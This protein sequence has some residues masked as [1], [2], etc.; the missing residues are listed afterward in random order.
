MKTI[1]TLLRNLSSKLKIAATLQTILNDLSSRPNLTIEEAWELW[2][3]ESWHSNG[4]T[5]SPLVDEVSKIPDSIVGVAT[6][7][8]LASKINRVTEIVNEYNESC[9]EFLGNSVKYKVV[10]RIYAN[11]TE[12]NA[13]GFDAIRDIQPSRGVHEHLLK[14]IDTQGLTP[15]IKGSHFNILTFLRKY[16]EEDSL[17]LSGYVS[18]ENMHALSLLF[19]YV[20]SLLNNKYKYNPYKILLSIKQ[21]FNAGFAFDNFNNKLHI[22]YST[23]DDT[24]SQIL[25]HNS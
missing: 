21:L 25:R 20:N 11:V 7:C 14:I 17:D 13:F 9:A 1:S 15:E 23:S 8:A 22:H 16:V 2:A 5:F 6:A 18:V 24:C 3:P 4:P 19:D 12:I 10:Y